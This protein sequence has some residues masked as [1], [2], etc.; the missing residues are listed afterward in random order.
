M[1]Q[2]VVEPVVSRRDKRQFVDLPW[3]LY[4]QDPN[5]VP[6][7]RMNQ[8]ELLGF[9][10][11]PF[12]QAADTQ[13]FLARRGHEVVGRV[14]AILNH[15]HNRVYNERRGFF[16]FFESVDD[17]KVASALF[18]SLRAWF[19]ERDIHALRGP[20]NPSMNY[21][22]GLLIH[23]F[24]SP[25]T[26]MM[27]YNADYYPRLIEGCGFAK[28]QDL[29]AFLGVLDQLPEVQ[30]RLGRLADQA[31]ER[32]GATIRPLNTRRFHEEAELFL[33]LY[34]G[35][36]QGTWGF[37]P[38]REPEI[39]ALAAGLKHLIVPELGAV[40]EVDGKPV[41][42]VLGLPDYNPVIKR[43]DGRLFPFGFLQLL[44]GKRNLK[45]VRVISINVTPEFQRWGLGMCLMRSM[46]P[47]GL[48]MGME[49][50]EFSWV[51]ES[52][53]L[54]RLGLEKG[55]AKLYK[56]YRMYDWEQG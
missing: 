55:G 11:H 49:S 7:L 28:S 48:A 42:S 1:L 18:E 35:A 45:R 24:D 44:W 8:E 53:D 22:C 15:E 14:T 9:R 26:F 4:R 39:Q 3:A 16:G 30:Q 17:Q 51:L 13:S 34:N 37:V 5:W 23:G 21:E 12:Y 38:L 40:A 6:P 41:G 33:R 31:Q 46:V 29:L 10:R 25:P 50:A 52:N 36:M 32:S 27:T 56:T 20:A 2:V 47:K 54:A 19:S 43:I